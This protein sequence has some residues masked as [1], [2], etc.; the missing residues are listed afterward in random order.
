MIDEVKRRR[1]ADGVVGIGPVVS[2]LI[3]VWDLGCFG[4]S[5]GSVFVTRLSSDLDVLGDL[6]LACAVGNVPEVAVP[7]TAGFK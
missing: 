2:P 5:F 4:C 3:P 7:R 6:Y 1:L